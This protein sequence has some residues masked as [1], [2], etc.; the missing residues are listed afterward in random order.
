MEQEKSNSLHLTL[1]RQ[2]E[3][4]AGSGTFVSVEEPAVWETEQT[5]LL[6]CDM[7][8]TH[9]CAGAVRRVEELAPAMDR[10]LRAAREQGILIIHAPSD[11]M[12]FYEGTPARLH[13]QSA[14]P[15]P[16]PGNVNTWARLDPTREAPLPI[17]DSDGGCD[18]EPACP[19]STPWTRQHPALH[20]ADEDALTDSG[21]EVYNL[22]QQHGIKNLMVMGVHTN[23]CVLGRSFAIRRMV[24]IG[25]NV[26]LIRDMTDAMYN[27][28]SAPYV[29]HF[30]GVALVVEHIEKYWCPT[31]TSDQITGGSPFRFAEN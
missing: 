1:R 2:K 26:A 20:I 10:L 8:D 27:S 21:V 6:V 15:S 17:D 23:M 9:W 5:A 25:M 16:A 28:R 19:I 24:G 12:P 18:D 4:A 3:T 14:P 31:L 7:W 30:R 13:A 29:S 22:F 11:T